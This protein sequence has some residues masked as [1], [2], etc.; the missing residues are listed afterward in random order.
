MILLIAAAYIAVSVMPAAAA[1]DV[2]FYGQSWFATWWDKTDG[3]SNG[4]TFDD[5][6]MT[7]QTDGAQVSRFGARFKDGPMSGLV[8]IGL[9]NGAG[10]RTRHI[11][12]EYD[13]GGFKLLVGQTYAKSFLPTLYGARGGQGTY[14]GEASIGTRTPMIRARFNAGPGELAISALTP[15]VTT[16]PAGFAAAFVEDIDSTMP[17]LEIAYDVKFGNFRL[18]LVGTH[19]SYEV[20]DTAT[21]VGY[22]VTS[23]AVMGKLQAAF[24]PLSL[25]AGMYSGQNLK[26]FGMGGLPAT[27]TSTWNGT[28]ILDTDQFGWALGAKFKVNDMF[29]VAA[30][31]G[32][33]DLS[34]PSGV[35]G[36]TDAEDTMKG[37]HLSAFVTVAKNFDINFEYGVKDWEDIRAAGGLPVDEGKDKYWGMEWILKF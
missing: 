26:E 28:Q 1:S 4:T 6:A 16:Y 20:V 19:Q 9:G 15:T 14:R 30:G 23:Y 27:A 36:V 21:N 31:Y 33:T 7:W 37:Y 25:S 11:Y 24:G 35:A 22:D 13:F 2:S 5:T 8:E 18:N 34:Q 17:R 32:E 29:A 12:G 3:T 10:I